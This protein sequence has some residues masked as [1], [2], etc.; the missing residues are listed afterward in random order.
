MVDNIAAEHLCAMG[1]APLLGCAPDGRIEGP[2]VEQISSAE[3]A[4]Q[5]AGTLLCTDWEAVRREGAWITRFAAA[6]GAQEICRLLD[7]EKQYLAPALIRFENALGGIVCVL[8]APVRT[9]GWLCRGRGGGGGGRGGGGAGGGG[10]GGG[11][12]GAP[13][14]P[15]FL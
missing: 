8:A 3:Y 11:G 5:W 9:L 10:G 7:E 6:A 1:F 15:R 2:C 4:R 12:R 13:P 14:P